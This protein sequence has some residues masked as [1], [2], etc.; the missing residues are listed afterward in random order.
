M[1]YLCPKCNI[2]LTKC[3]VTSSLGKFSA[4][5]LPIKHFTTKESSDIFPYVCSEC[6]YI[7]LYVEKP[8]NFK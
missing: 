7:E 5:K 1:Q 8:G 6:G 3:T 4:V 2:I